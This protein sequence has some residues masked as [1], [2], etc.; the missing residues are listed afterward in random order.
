MEMKGAAMKWT[1]HW[2]RAVLLTGAIAAGATSLAAC[3]TATTEGASAT[4]TA[5][6]TPA[7]TTTGPEPITPEEAAWVNRVTKL[8]KRLEKT[9]LRG[10]IVTQSLMLSQ[11]KTFAT[12]KKRLGRVPS[13]RFEHPFAVAQ[14]ACRKF[15]KAAAQLRIAS[16]NVDASGAV[17]AGTASEDNF[18]KAFERA[19]AYAG[20]AVNRLSAAVVKTKMIRDSLPS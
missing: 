10:G 4:T 9:T 14:S 11:A 12:C 16:A 6:A 1:R 20:N 13:S 15:R 7:E 18:N 3:S 2:F 8:E 19:N 5:P 17:E